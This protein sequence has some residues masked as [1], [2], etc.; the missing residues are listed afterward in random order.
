MT[1]YYDLLGVSKNANLNE[2]KAAYRKQAL[3]WHPD[4][5]KSPEASEKFKEINQAFEVL[6]DPKKKEI[7]DQ[8]GPEAFTRGGFGRAG[9]GPQAYTYQTGP[10]TYTYTSSGGQS[11]FEGYDFGGF[12]DPFEIFEQFFG[13][14][15]PMGRR[16]P[17][18]SV[19]QIEITFDEAVHGTTK[20]V[21]IDG[22]R[23][24]IKIPA[25]V[26]DGMRIRFSDFDLSLSVLPDSRFKR[27][28]QDVYVEV[29]I[30]LTTA[31]LG[32]TVSVPTIDKEVRLKVRSGTQPNTMLRLRGQGIPYPH[33]S[34]RGDQYIIFKIKIPEKVSSRGKKLLEELEEEL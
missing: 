10:F 1:D 18:R 26:D 11:P 23:K 22:K 12:S 34:R 13:F 28:G 19:Y 14:Q 4:R 20:E 9:A 29:P 5:N 15:S 30:S 2:I 25:G 32:G 27:E 3:K 8:Y 21:E 24:T 31:I 7:Y 6:S 17:K 33:S 16:R